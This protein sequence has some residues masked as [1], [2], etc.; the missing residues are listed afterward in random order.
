MGGR[1][2]AKDERIAV[3]DVPFQ[4]LYFERAAL[5]LLSVP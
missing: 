1:E 3:S 4:A 5:D 2:H